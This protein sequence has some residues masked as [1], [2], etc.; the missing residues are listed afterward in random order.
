MGKLRFASDVAA[1][2]SNASRLSDPT[3][4]PDPTRR[5]NRLDD[6]LELGFV[7]GHDGSI[8]T[9]E[10][11]LDRRTIRLSAARPAMGT[12]LSVV[13]LADARDRLDAAF[14]RA[15]MEVDRLVGIFSRYD[16]ASALSDLNATGHLRGP[17]LELLHVLSRARSYYDS[18]RGVF[19]ATVAPLVDLYRDWFRRPTPLAPSEVDVR[20]A[21]ARVG[22]ANVLLSRREVRF[23]LPGMAVTLD[24]IA[25]GYIVDR[26]AQT[27]EA[28]RVRNYLIDAGG[29]IRAAGRKEGGR[30]WT[31]AVRD[32][33]GNEACPDALH[34][35]GRAVATSGGYENC[36][37]RNQ[38][39]HHIIDVETGRSPTRCASVSVVAPTT[40]AADA[41]ATCVFIMGPEDG[42][43]FVDA[44]A[45]CAC[46]VIDT[47]GRTLRSRRWKSVSPGNHHLVE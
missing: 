40:M 29:D 20:D 21:S 3:G 17:P 16:S 26:I 46:L 7:R 41:L 43:D 4:G 23:G 27:L 32:P 36:Y 37:D 44:L 1:S 38:L 18:T 11:R 19:D 33:F 47:N 31:V 10:T 8:A 15:F 39:L 6:L 35:H 5:D 13:A 24:G 2:G 34:L 9:E 42:A 12:L 30:P 45:G 22:A 28:A 25:K 14:G